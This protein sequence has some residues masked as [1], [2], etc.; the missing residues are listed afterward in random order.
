MGFNSSFFE[1]FT[2]HIVSLWLK[3][4]TILHFKLSKELVWPE[5]G[6]IDDLANEFWVESSD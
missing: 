4:K 5:C 6:C 1:S 2:F 3:S